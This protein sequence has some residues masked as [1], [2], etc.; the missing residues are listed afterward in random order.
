MYMANNVSLVIKETLNTLTNEADYGT[1]IFVEVDA[2]ASTGFY[3]LEARHPAYEQQLDNSWNLYFTFSNDPYAYIVGTV[4]DESM[5]ATNL[6]IVG[7]FYTPFNDKSYVVMTQPTIRGESGLVSHSFAAGSKIDVRADVKNVSLTA[8]EYTITGGN[9][10]YINTASPVGALFGSRLSLTFGDKPSSQPNMPD[11]VAADVLI[12]AGNSIAVAQYDIEFGFDM[13]GCS[14]VD[15]DSISITGHQ[16]P[17]PLYFS[18]VEVTVSNDAGYVN[19][20]MNDGSTW[21]TPEVVSWAASTSSFGHTI[22]APNDIAIAGTDTGSA[23][24]P[25]GLKA[26]VDARGFSNPAQATTTVS[27]IVEL[28]TTAEATAQSDS[29]RAVT[30]AGLA[31]R[32]KTSTT[33]SAGNGLSGGGALSSNVSLALGT[34]STIT[35]ATANSA[36]GTTHTHALTLPTASATAQGIVELATTAE[37]TAQTDTARAVTPAGLADRVKTST[38]VTAGNGLSGGGALSSSVTLSLGTPSTITVDTT[39]ESSLGTHTHELTLPSASTSRAGVVELATNSESITGISTELASTPAG[40]AAYVSSK[41]PDTSIA[42]V[43]LTA[44]DDFNEAFNAAGRPA[45]CFMQAVESWA[46]WVPANLPDVFTTSMLMYRSV[47]IETLGDA[48]TNGETLEQKMYIYDLYPGDGGQLNAIYERA[49][50]VYTGGIS[51]DSWYDIS[52]VGSLGYATTSVYGLTKLATLSETSDPDNDTMAVTPAG[53]ASALSELGGSSYS[54]LIM[55]ETDNMNAVITPGNYAVWWGT[56]AAPANTPTIAL[57]S[58]SYGGGYLTVSAVPSGGILQTFYMTQ[59][60]V[61]W[62]VPSWSEGLECYFRTGAQDGSSWTGW[63]LSGIPQATDT[64][65]GKV[66]LATIT[67]AEEGTS[68]YSGVTP[69]GVKAYFDSRPASATVAGV[70]EL[71]TYSEALTGT[72]V[73][74]AITPYTMKYYTDYNQYRRFGMPGFHATWGATALGSTAPCAAANTSTAATASTTYMI[75]FVL[76][77]AITMTNLSIVVATLAASSTCKIGLYETNN[78]STTLQ[79]TATNGRYRPTNILAQSGALDC[80]TAGTKTYTLPS[81]ITLQPGVYF[82]AVIVSTAA[83]LKINFKTTASGTGVG[84][85]NALWRDQGTAAV[86]PV[87]FTTT[88]PGTATSATFPSNPSV[89]SGTTLVNSCPIVYFNYTLA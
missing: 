39:N 73:E 61:D 57:P 44:T 31:D 70:I 20:V 66:R 74:R 56:D 29:T 22:L 3:E 42:T 25:A 15:S 28:A 46:S 85:F 17:F 80:S 54:E 10:P 45:Y 7:T 36:S 19:Y 47:F 26:H 68:M 58:A 37:A 51:W 50:Q 52:P 67:E 65:M 77:R 60:Y 2:A 49:G 18:Y 64:V 21:Q 32:V 72:D 8:N 5:S 48:F 23:V 62:P 6:M 33:V 38:S 27:G 69:A 89:I 30:P 63:V 81:A 84:E 59:W 1:I 24:T 71:A 75:P 16:G 86:T 9:A 11:S 14:G 82:F 35:N 43:Y 55:D 12:Y 78:N 76:P 83:T 34:P 13:T 40:V 53:L 87:A 4:F 79:T 88:A 41:I